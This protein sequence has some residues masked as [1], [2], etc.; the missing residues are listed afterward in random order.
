MICANRALYRSEGDRRRGFNPIASGQGRGGC[1]LISGS[2]FLRHHAPALRISRSTAGGNSGQAH[3]YD[4]LSV[5]AELPRIGPKLQGGMHVASPTG[6]ER[7][8]G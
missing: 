7:R 3:C 8:D 2:D 5:K 4:T 6:Y 1:S